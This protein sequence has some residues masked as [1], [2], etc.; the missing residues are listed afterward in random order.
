[1]DLELL[2]AMRRLRSEGREVAVATVVK[3]EGSAYRRE[4]ARMLLTK[5]GEM[6]SAV[7]GGC[8]EGDLLEHTKTLV[9]GEPGKLLLYDLTADDDDVWG[10]GLGCNGKIT[11]YLELIDDE[12]AEALERAMSSDIPRQILVTV[13]EP[14]DSG[15]AEGTR[16]W[17]DEHGVMEGSLGDPDIDQA[18]LHAA[19]HRLESGRSGSEIL[20]GKHALNVYF[21]VFQPPLHLCIF[22]AGH[23]ALP[24][25]LFGHELGFRVT[26]VDSRPHLATKER[27]PWADEVI[28]SEAEE[29]R[30]K[31]KI[32]PATY[33]VVMT[34]NFIQ[35]SLILG[36]L[37]Q[38]EADYIGML[39]PLQRTERLLNEVEDRIGLDREKAE[40]ERRVFAPVGLNLGSNSAEEIALSIAGEILARYRR[41][42]AG[43]LKGHRG[44][45]HLQDDVSA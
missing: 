44:S 5:D 14:G 30:E 39:G 28:H 37:L 25:A 29:I 23:D 32:T 12:L 35:D 38:S 1:M 22:G 3:V 4:G 36:E 34:H 9:H 40:V 10:L 33:A 6:V 31:V 13:L 24:L 16:I 18:V 15:L 11:V 41:R 8:L 42:P 45:I 20:G 2:E 7:S 43:F 19:K 21:D 17:V 27:F 26:V